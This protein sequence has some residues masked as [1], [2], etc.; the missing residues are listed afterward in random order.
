MDSLSIS[1]SFRLASRARE[2]LSKAAR[3]SDHDLRVLVSHANLLDALMSHLSNFDIPAHSSSSSLVLP[4]STGHDYFYEYDSDSDS[5]EDEGSDDGSDGSE[6]DDE[7]DRLVDND[8]DDLDDLDDLDDGFGLEAMRSQLISSHS[9]P[10]SPRVLPSPSSSSPIFSLSLSDSDSDDDDDDEKDIYS[11]SDDSEDDGPDSFY[12][13]ANMHRF[14]AREVAA[15]SSDDLD[16]DADLPELVRVVSHAVAPHALIPDSCSDESDYSSLSSYTT[17]D[18]DDEHNPDHLALPPPVYT[19]V[20][21]PQ[22]V[23]FEKQCPPSATL[24]DV[25]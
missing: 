4:S 13:S 11:D 18:D 14:V 16:L 22:H 21:S 19:P 25:A 5:D 23:H 15:D 3:K 24:V 9:A 7:V 12:S 17:S 10:S 20:C 2:K 6:D 1:Q 8:Y